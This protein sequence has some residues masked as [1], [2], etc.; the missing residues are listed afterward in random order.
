MTLEESLQFLQHNE[1]FATFI[2]VIHA[3]REESIADLHN[4][5]L[6]TIQQTSGKILTYDQILQ[7]V[8]WENIRKKHETTFNKLV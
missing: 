2:S 5:D 8:S 6:E 3:L 7:M 4:S 1:H